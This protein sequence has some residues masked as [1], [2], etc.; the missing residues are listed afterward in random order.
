MNLQEDEEV[1]ASKLKK[2]II[3]SII[4]LSFLCIVIVGLIIYKINNP[5]TIVAYIDN[6]KIKNFTEILDIQEDEKGNT[7]IYISIRDFATYLKEGNPQINYIT[8]KG[9]YNPKTEEEGKCYII[10]DNYE[11]A[12]FTENTKTIYKLNLHNTGKENS[13]YEEVVI[14]NDVFL[15]NGKLYASEYGIEKGYNVDISYNEKKKIINIYTMEYLVNYYQAQLEK[16]NAENYGLL[17]I[18]QDNYQNCKSVFE[19]L[20]IVN[21]TEDKYGIIKA[22]DYSTYILEPQYDDIEYISDSNTFLVESNKKKGIFSTDGKRKIDLIY[23]NIYSMGQNSKLYVVESKGQFGVVDENGNIVIYPENEK[24][25]IDVGDF[26]YNG[27]KNGYFIL[28]KLI[29]VKQNNKWAF[30]NTNGKMVTDGYIYT[31]IGC[32]KTK[33]GNNVYGLLQ[34][35]EYD[36]VVVGDELGKY[37]FMES[38]GNDNLLP[39][40]LEQIYTKVTEGKVNYY[41]TVNDKDYEVIKYLKQVKQKK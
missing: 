4:I 32:N 34:L 39:H 2:V 9:D 40:V 28:N 25:G 20:L 33:T 15:S 31:Q 14:D 10:R 7:Q 26:P 30:Y 18:K 27:I 5:S 36:V 24:I 41:M 1:K 16:Q 17:E 38:D 13:D 6:N 19:N 29:P 37:W 12:V 3:I 11:V 21:S 22:D 35:A 8:Y 23:D